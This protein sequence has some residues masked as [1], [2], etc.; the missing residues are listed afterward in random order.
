MSP[1]D[2]SAPRVL[3]APWAVEAPVPPSA[4][5][6]SPVQVKVWTFDAEEKPMLVVPDANDC[7]PPV[8]PLR[9]LSPTPSPGQALQVG[10]APVLPCK[11][12]PVAPTAVACRAPALFP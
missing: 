12:S 9:L 3:M 10:A 7:V 5:G 2:V 8:S 4:T 1:S 11:H 6:R